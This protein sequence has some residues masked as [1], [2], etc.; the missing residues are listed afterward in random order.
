MSVRSLTDLR[1][2]PHT[3]WGDRTYWHLITGY[4]EAKVMT[5]KFNI[6]NIEMAK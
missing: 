2:Y 1:K 5:M 6:T 4:L 3:R